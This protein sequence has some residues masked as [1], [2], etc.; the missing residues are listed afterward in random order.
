MSVIPSEEEICQR[1]IAWADA[2]HSVFNILFNPVDKKVCISNAFDD[3]SH[4]PSGTARKK[5]KLMGSLRHHTYSKAVVL[6]VTLQEY[7][8]EGGP[9]EGLTREESWLYITRLVGDYIDK[10][11]KWRRNH[12]APPFIK[13]LWTL[14]DQKE[15]HF[16]HVHILFF[17]TSWVLKRAIAQALWPWGNIDFKRVGGGTAAHYITKYLTKME[18]EDFFHSMT[19]GRRIRAYALSHELSHLKKVKPKTNW[20]YLSSPALSGAMDSKEDFIIRGFTITK[21]GTLHYLPP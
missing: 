9:F 11:N 4:G 15:R 12:G 16:P 2:R 18:G 13:Y 6:T 8:P 17:D 20:V 14:E 3:S 21:D 5:K 19:W 10:I 1:Y 7:R